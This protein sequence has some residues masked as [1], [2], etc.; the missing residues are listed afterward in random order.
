AN[1]LTGEQGRKDVEHVRRA[2]GAALRIPPESA[3][4]ASTG[5]IG[6]PL[7]VEKITQGLPRL[8]ESLGASCEPAAEAMMTT[9]THPKVARRSLHLGGREVSIL[10][11]AQ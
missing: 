3:F 1:A 10:G 2:L 9:D 6:V 8:V 5:V 4:T 7:P 11:L